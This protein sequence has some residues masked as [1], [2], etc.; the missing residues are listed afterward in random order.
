MTDYP[1]MYDAAFAEDLVQV[2]D[3]AYAGY[4]GGPLAYHVWDTQDW[5]PLAGE[6][7]LPIW[8]AGYDGIGEGLAAARALRALEVPKRVY[9]AVDMEGRVD[10]DYLAHF[11]QILGDAG[12]RVWV[13]G[14][15]DTVFSN[16]ALSGY[17]VA[18]YAGEGA[19]MYDHP[20]VRATQYVPGELYDS[21]TVK[22]WT[23]TN[24]RWWR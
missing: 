14:S 20:Q 15:A 1:R 23:F 3:A 22:P 12:Y 6:R 4:Y 7:K 8:V 24:G 21:S 5:V 10:R 2:P 17:W 19:F 16:P 13:Y 11:G 9:T 18:D